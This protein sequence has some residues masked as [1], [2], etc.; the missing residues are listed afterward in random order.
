MTTS[1]QTKEIYQ[2]RRRVIKS[3]LKHGDVK[4]LA[5]KLI[6][7]FPD[8]TKSELRE[9]ANYLSQVFNDRSTRPFRDSL[10]RKIEEVWDGLN[11][12]DLDN[13]NVDDEYRLAMSKQFS[14]HVE[15]ELT[16]L[17]NQRGKDFKVGYKEDS[18][19][20]RICLDALQ[21]RMHQKYPNAKILIN[22][23][24]KLKSGNYVADLVVTNS[25]GSPPVLIIET[26]TNNG[27]L[28]RAKKESHLAFLLSESGAEQGLL[29]I[30]DKGEIIEKWL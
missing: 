16:E 12:G 23:R 30:L 21:W 28:M 9:Y 13:F 15:Y 2:T 22:E 3:H 10:A 26:G 25:I 18:V 4:V 5:E 6:Q 24:L 11:F 8:I 27:H 19:L 7:A 29:A 20:P 14:E 1:N 17:A